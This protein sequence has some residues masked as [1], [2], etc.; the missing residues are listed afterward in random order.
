MDKIGQSIDLDNDKNQQFMA[1][2]T[3]DP[4]SMHPGDLSHKDL[5]ISFESHLTKDFQEEFKAKYKT[6]IDF[7]NKVIEFKTKYG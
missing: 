1:R 4:L 6:E 7:L 2:F 5:L 3:Q